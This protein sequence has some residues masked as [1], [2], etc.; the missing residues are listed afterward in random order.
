M[1]S[2]WYF[3]CILEE[4]YVRM[5][6]LFY[7][8]CR[9]RKWKNRGMDSCICLAFLFSSMIIYIYDDMSLFLNSTKGI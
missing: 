4:G 5:F 8:G 2:Q 9:D 3:I 7:L 6:A 1:L